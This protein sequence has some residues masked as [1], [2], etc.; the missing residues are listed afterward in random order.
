MVEQD[1]GQGAGRSASRLSTV[2]SGRAAKA[3]SVGAKTVN[4]PSPLQRVDQAGLGHGGHQRG[5]AAIGHGGIDDVS[6]SSL[7]I[8]SSA[9]ASSAAGISTASMTWMT[10]LLVSISTITTLD[11]LIMTP[12]SLTCTAISAAANRGH[13]LAV[14]TDHVSGH[15]FAGNH[16]VEQDVGQ[17]AGRVGQQALDRTS[18]RA[19][20]ASSVGAKTVNGPSPLSV[21]TRPASVTAVTRVVKSLRP[22]RCRRCPSPSS[23]LFFGHGFVSGRNQH[24]VDDMDDAIAGLDINNDDS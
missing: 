15:H 9:M 8:S 18:G 3:S 14:K 11:S 16:V 6:I 2:P 24:S 20:K 21:S 12:S 13:H 17:G 10:P 23:A 5:E 7:G 1:V 4:G 22:R 19:A